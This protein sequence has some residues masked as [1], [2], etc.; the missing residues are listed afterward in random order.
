M[1]IIVHKI[2]LGKQIAGGTQC[3]VMLVKGAHHLADY[4]DQNNLCPFVLERITFTNNV[5]VA[6]NC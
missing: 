2:T 5:T 3:Y 1:I 4:A 6:S